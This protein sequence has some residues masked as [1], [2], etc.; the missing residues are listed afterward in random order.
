MALGNCS[1]PRPSWSSV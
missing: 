1:W